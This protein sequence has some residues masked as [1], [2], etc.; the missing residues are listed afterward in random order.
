MRP[1]M[2][3]SNG[4]QRTVSYGDTFVFHRVELNEEYGMKKLTA[5]LMLLIVALTVASAQERRVVVPVN[6]SLFPLY[7]FSR[8]V[9]VVNNVQLN[10]GMG[11]A[12]ELNCVAAGVVSIVG[13]DV[14]GIQANVVNIAGGPV[15]GAQI[16]VV[17][18]TRREVNGAQVGVVNGSLRDLRGPQVGVV[19]TTFGAVSGPQ[20]GVVNVARKSAMQTGVVNASLDA[21]GVQLGVVNIARHNTG[22]PIGIVN[23]VLN[24][25]RT[26]AMSWVD[27]TG[28]LNVGLIHGSRR[29]YNIYT[30]ASDVSLETVS[31]GLG[32]GAHFDS[33]RSW[34]RIEA[35]GSSV[36][37]ADDIFGSA[38][39]L[40]RARVY[41]GYQFGPIALIAGG[42]F[43]YLL[44]L[45]D[46]DVEIAPLHG[47]EF[48]FSTVDHRFWPGVFV[49]IQL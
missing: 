31:L 43:N 1:A 45:S 46:S 33:R 23:I 40:F 15:S 26:H 19:N 37:S 39:T 11:Y 29:T 13:Q 4:P 25:G 24:G 30:A 12:D 17:N 48:G 44:D 18:L 42:S 20:S 2:T 10:V 34:T 6:I 5:A 36:S 7:G 32:L 21:S 27:E 8:S 3:I 28:L 38:A 16:G 49:G 35:I 14:R 22:A 9:T 41:K 47:Y